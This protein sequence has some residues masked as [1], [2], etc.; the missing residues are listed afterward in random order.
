MTTDVLFGHGSGQPIQFGFLTYVSRSGSTMLGELLSRHEAV[1]VCIEANLPKELFGLGA[2]RSPTFQTPEELRAYLRRVS[3]YS[4]LPSWGLKETELVEQLSES[5]PGLTGGGLVRAL[6]EA[7]RL[8]HAPRSSVCIYK[9]SPAMPW[10]GRDLLQAFPDFR[11]IHLV[12]DPRAV[13]ASQKRSINPYTGRPFS[14][15][16]LD[17]ARQWYRSVVE[18]ERIDSERWMNL[19][20][21]DVLDSHERC[22]EQVL[23]FLGASGGNRAEAGSL[24]R[25]L[26]REEREIHRLVSEDPD[27]AR[28]N[29]WQSELS[30]KE[31]QK[32]EAVLGELLARWGYEG[33]SAPGLLERLRIRAAWRLKAASLWLRRASRLGIKLLT[34]DRRYWGKLRAMFRRRSGVRGK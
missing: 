10:D 28:A 12:R 22:V 4:K 20:Y 21:E 29:S 8:E 2:Y 6:M 25:H 19:R 5:L 24:A 3:T 15:G 13:Y 18:A 32:M 16:P 7:Y 30:M 34:G 17:A 11:L 14:K 23:T 9:G 33:V 1:C 26:P 31:Q 27:R